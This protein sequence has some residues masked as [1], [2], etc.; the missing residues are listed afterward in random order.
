MPLILKIGLETLHIYGYAKSKYTV[1]RDREKHVYITIQN[2]VLF[3]GVEKYIM[4]QLR[5]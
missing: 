5:I 3:N 1:R 4:T 2:Y